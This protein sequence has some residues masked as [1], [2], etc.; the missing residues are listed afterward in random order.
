MSSTNDK[1]ALFISDI[2][3]SPNEPATAA[4]FLACLASIA[5]PAGAASS[6]TIL[7]D[8]FDYW[9]GDDDLDDPF[10]ARIVA[11]LRA[12]A[13]SGVGIAF[14]A[15]NRDFLIGEAFAAAAGLVLLP[16]PCVREIAGEPSL[17]THGDLLCTDDAD[18]QRFRRQV[19]DPAWRSQ[20]LAKPL[21]ARKAE[22]EALRARSEQEKKIKPQAIMDVNNEAVTSLLRQHQVR[23]LIHG[24]TH[25]Q[26]RHTH[27]V[28]GNPCTRWVLGDWGASRGTALNGSPAGWHFI[29]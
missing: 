19:R 26:G 8:L 25:R 20:F 14:M 29:D 3:L 12:L 5:A 6:L 24:H 9:A 23:T 15:G 7:G 18:Y 21:T 17:L 11:A 27:I 10:N 16:D 28:A 1:S 4:R 2:H 22:I 13:D